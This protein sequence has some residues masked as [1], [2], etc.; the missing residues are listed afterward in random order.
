MKP[1]IKKYRAFFLQIML[2]LIP[3][4]LSPETPISVLSGIIPEIVQRTK[5]FIVEDLR[6]ARR[7]LRKCGYPGDFSDV[8]FL[9]IKSTTSSEIIRAYLNKSVDENIGLISESGLPCVA[10]PGSTVVWQA[11]DLNIPIQAL[12]GPNSILLT[13]AGSGFN[14]Q[15]FTFHGYLPIKQNELSK[16]I[17]QIE[18]DLKKTGAT[19]LFIETP[20]RTQSLFEELLKLCDA[21]T[22]LCI[23]KNL[24]MESENI[25]SK[26]MNDWKKN[27][28]Q[29]NK[30][31]V[32]FALGKPSI[33]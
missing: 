8:D 21:N 5:I 19:Q 20:F 22:G 33:V 25:S 32:V 10:D 30:Q 12:P 23:G 28:P 7:F 14:G 29:I 13:L 11:H 26:I 9:E 24:G 4:P 15:N 31:L 16:K 17:S 27:K 2:F 18:S 3:V 6:S 1:C